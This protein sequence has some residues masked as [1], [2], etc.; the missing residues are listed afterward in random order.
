MR[1]R[2]KREEN[3]G[4][5]REERKGEWREEKK[6]E[7]RGERKGETR[8]YTEREINGANELHKSTKALEEEMAADFG[9]SRACAGDELASGTAMFLAQCTS[10][11]SADAHLP[12][13][14]PVSVAKNTFTLHARSRRRFFPIN[15]YI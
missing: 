8:V 12:C 2:E 15:I 13:S 14:C 10:S 7:R 9:E 4:E 5:R 3:E 11:G 1:K 6:R